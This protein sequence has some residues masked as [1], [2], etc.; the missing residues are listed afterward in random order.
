MDTKLTLYDES[1]IDSLEWPNTPEA[2]QARALFVPMLKEGVE[3]YIQNSKTKLYLLKVDDHIIPVTINE[4]EYDNSYLTSNYVGI[5]LLEEKIARKFPRLFRLQKPFIESFGA[6]LKGIKINKVVIVNNWLLT[7]NIYPDLTLLQTNEITDFFQRRFPDHTIIFR[8]LYQRKCSSLA[9]D[10][11][12]QHYRVI[13]TRFVYLYDPDDKQ[14][15]TSKTHYHHRRDRRLLESEGYQ[16]VRNEMIQEGEI[17][18]LLQLYNYTY[19]SKHTSYSPQYTE[20]FIKKAIEKKFFN[21]IGLKKDGDIQGV[22]GCCMRNGTMIVPFLGFDPSKGEPNHLYRMLT[23][24]AID[25][26]EKEQMLLNDG[27]GGATPKLKRGMKAC[28]EYIAIYDRHLPW[29]RRLFWALAEKVVNH[30][31]FPLI[32]KRMDQSYS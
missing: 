14:H 23:I 11:K 3:A 16:V 5:K 7:T 22:M 24:L 21:L 9:R 12:Q 28:P 4:K 27:S 26:A 25:E 13:G 6:I 31:A 32:E 8:S 10:L 20:K 1:T 2:L 19:I 15:F 17:G 29:H 18:R 30:I